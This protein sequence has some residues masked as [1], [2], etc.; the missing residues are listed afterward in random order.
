MLRHAVILT[1]VLLAGTA[2]AGTVLPSGPFQGVELDTLSPE[3][4]E[5]ITRASEDFERVLQGKRPKNAALDEK[6]PLP[7][8]GG[9]LFYAGKGY[10]LTVIKSL[11]SFGNAGDGLQGYVYGPVLSFPKSFAPGNMSEVVSLRF[12]TNQQLQTLTGGE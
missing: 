2:L 4:R 8:D 7:A 10:R 5:I 6:A 11:S 1:F 9:T 3:Q 12:Y